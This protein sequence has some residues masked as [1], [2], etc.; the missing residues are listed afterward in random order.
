MERQARVGADRGNRK[1]MT[2]PVLDIGLY[3]F[4]LLSF[5]LLAA[6]VATILSKRHAIG[7]LIGVELILNAASI[8]LVAFNHYVWSHTGSLDGQMFA[9]FVIVL[10]AAE[11][12]IALAIVLSFYH[13]FNS[14]DVEQAGALR[15]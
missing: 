4:V 15:G 3:H 11:A 14:V 7:I 8:N 1:I 10:A 12:A 9:L 5:G 13:N 6:G 2:N